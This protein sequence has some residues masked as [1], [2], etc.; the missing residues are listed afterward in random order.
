MTLVAIIVAL[1][2]ERITGHLPE[3]ASP[4]V[5]RNYLAALRWMLPFQ[6]LWHSMFSIVLIMAPP[7]ALIWWLQQNML[8]PIPDILLSGF[9]LILCLGPR[10]LA[11]DVRRWLDA[12][13]SEDHE[14][15]IRIG[16]L[17]QQGPGRLS[18]IKGPSSRNLLGAL[19]I[20]SH[21]R[22]FGVLLWFLFLGPIG[23][24]FYRIV[25]RLP[26]LLNEWEEDSRAAIAAENLHALAAWLPARLTAALF[27]LA[28]SLDDAIAEYRRLAHQTLLGW[29]NRTWAV[30]AEVASGAVEFENKNGGTEV[31][32]TLELAAR[33]VLGMQFRALMILLAL[34]ALS[35]SGS[36]F[37]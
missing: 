16:R 18:E 6:R 1:I 33:E 10:D 31:P 36:F 25:S 17:L 27:G 24:V 13:A 19:F 3:W 15:A 34:V 21:E 37:A 12:R 14:T 32:A 35:T 29:R 26:R 7:L 23:A 5:L 28:G 8:E 2:V 20:Q 22:L 11:E 9:T 4:R 30:L